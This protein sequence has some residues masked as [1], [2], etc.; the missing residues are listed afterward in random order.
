MPSVPHKERGPQRRAGMSSP[1]S[2]GAPGR[3]VCDA[4]G[5]DGG[6][7]GGVDAAVAVGGAGVRS[8]IDEPGVRRLVDEATFQR[9]P[10]T[11]SVIAGPSDHEV[12]SSL[13]PRMPSGP[14]DDTPTI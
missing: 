14:D 12:T 10:R 7:T 1:A 8:W 13:V 4:A 2:G 3:V 9:A 6:G 11:R 5:A